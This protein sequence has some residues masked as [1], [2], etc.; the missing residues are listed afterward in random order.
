MQIREING[1]RISVLSLGTVQ[2]GLNYGISNTT[3]K[4]DR[5]QSFSILDTAMEEGISVLDT[6]AAY[7]DS[8][9]VIG[10]WLKERAD[11]PF[12]VTKAVNVPF[13]SRSICY[14]GLR[15]SVE[16]SLERLGI[17]QIPLLMMHHFENYLA[18]PENMKA[19]FLRL[20]EEGLI[21][22]WGLSAYGHHDYFE[23]A[24]SGCD[25]VQI[26]IN[27][28]DQRQIES[29]GLQELEKNGIMI[30]ARSVY[31]QGLIFRD[32]DQLDERMAFCCEPLLKLRRLCLEFE[33]SPAQLALA[34]VLG[35]PGVASLVLGSE[36]ALQVRQNAE[37]IRKLPSLN[38]EQMEQIRL[39]FKDTAPRVLNPSEW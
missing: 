31:L 14:D 4:P 12:I 25:A 2:L 35:L 3:G 16:G 15:S 38:T 18:D 24:R 32:P 28:L 9:Q 13:G 30:F 36:T 20:K 33:L 11:R 5:E 27:L 29:G 23:L 8:E 39:Q 10:A 17:S 37:M 21:G 22:A 26:P 7:G 34:Y 6:A 19:A 1:V